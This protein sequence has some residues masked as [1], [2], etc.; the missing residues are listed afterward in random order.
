MKRLTAFLCAAA[1]LLLA[2]CAREAQ[3]ARSAQVFAMD[4]V[5]NMTAYGGD[6]D[7]VDAAET[8]IYRLEA[9]FSRTREESDVSRLNE[10]GGG[11]V[12]EE[13]YALLEAAKAE[14]LRTGGAFDV[15]VAP[16]MDLWGFTKTEFRVPTAEE[17][18]GALP[19]VGAGHVRLANGAAALDEGTRIDLG[20]IVKG[21]AADRVEAIFRAHGVRSAVADLGGN[22][23]LLGSK[24]DGSDWRVGVKD[25]RRTEEADAYAV[26]LSLCDAF[27]VTS[28]GYQRYFE[29]DGRTYHH[30]LDPASGL[31][32]KSGLL[33]VTVVAN[34]NGKDYDGARP[35]N[36][37][38]C[39][40]LSTALFVMGEEKALAFHLLSD[41]AF[42]LVLVTDDGRVV[43]TKGLEGRFEE[44]EGSGYRYETTP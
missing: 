17:L 39:D 6:G 42:E 5:M 16:L 2:G 4:T 34:A 31:P 24:P 36:A 10:N 12:S 30:I 15:T 22:L 19:A 43:V 26:I 40:A 14:S 8:E 13:V 1:L 38:A 20:G 9:L 7:A 44:V 28:G 25:P 27:A 3:T 37:A 11:A 21:Y 35:A 29:R 18:E 33:S 23:L 41:E 32:A